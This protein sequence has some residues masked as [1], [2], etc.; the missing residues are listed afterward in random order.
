MAD[1]ATLSESGTP[2]VKAVDIAYIRIS[3]PDLDAMEAFVSDFGLVVAHRDD[4]VLISRGLE[5]TPFL[6]VVHRG[7]AKFIGLGVRSGFR[8]RP[9]CTGRG[10][11]RLLSGA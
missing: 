11:P 8:R 6:H 3:A 7:P 5:P 10:C 1:T 4:D 2:I 9:G